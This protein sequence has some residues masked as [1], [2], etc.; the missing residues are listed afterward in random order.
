[1]GGTTKPQS[2]SGSTPPSSKAA[3]PKE[4]TTA[5][6]NIAMALSTNQPVVRLFAALAL[7]GGATA[8]SATPLPNVK[9]EW[10]TDS[11][12][13]CTMCS[14]QSWFSQYSPLSPLIKVALGD[15]SIIPAIG[16]GRVHMQMQANNE[17]NDVVV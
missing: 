12:A 13:S 16:I 14:N 1:M 11:G 3:A 6:V 2:P 5:T 17:W 7:V 10:I 8:L 15:S 4:P 9:Y